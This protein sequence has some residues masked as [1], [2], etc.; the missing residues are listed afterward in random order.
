MSDIP[1]T[2]E[3]SLDRTRE[4]FLN[5]RSQDAIA[6]CRS[7]LDAHD[8]MPEM[9]GKFYQIYTDALLR[10][11]LNQEAIAVARTWLASADD[12]R[13]QALACVALANGLHRVGELLEAARVL[14]DAH[15]LANRAD[16]RTL[17][18][19]VL[20]LR[21]DLLWTQGDDSEKAAFLLQQA[22]AIHEVPG[23]SEQQAYV[24]TSLSIVYDVMG[25]P[26]DAIRAGLRGVDLCLHSGDTYNLSILYN[27]LGEWYQRIFAMQTAREYHEKALA[28]IGD[29]SAIDLRR[30]LGVDLVALGETER[31]LGLLHEAVQMGADGDRDE[32]MQALL[33]L[34]EA[35]YGLGRLAEARRY[36][37]SLLRLA[38][39]MNSERHLARVSLL[40]GRVADA[41]GDVALARRCLQ[42][43][44][45]FA[46]KASDRHTLW[47]AHAAVFERNVQT[48]PTFAAINLSAA[49]DVL[50]SIAQAIDDPL[51][52]QGFLEAAP[53]ARVLLLRDAPYIAAA[54]S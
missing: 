20:R 52:R 14:D 39:E 54:R 11:N 27:N 19:R 26:S 7:A 23:D 46:R 53:V 36:G 17:V 32:L 1:P 44:L 47:Q 28:I 30:N 21:A 41:E 43:A 42:D 13:G 15:A 51:L 5:G 2:I 6:G 48:Q 16:E 24:L 18:G 50:E 4:A 10:C 49:L 25:R 38:R 33:G 22:L 34:A 8:L 37:G 31:G 40:L 12:A 45:T 9:R 3:N 35:L 29:A